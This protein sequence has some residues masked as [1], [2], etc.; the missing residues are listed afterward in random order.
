MAALV[1]GF[2]I[3][4]TTRNINVSFI[5]HNVRISHSKTKWTQKHSKDLN[6][7]FKLF[8]IH[9]S[10]KHEKIDYIPQKWHTCF[11][12]YPHRKPPKKC[13]HQSFH[14]VQWRVQALVSRSHLHFGEVPLSPHPHL[15]WYHKTH[16]SRS[17]DKAVNCNV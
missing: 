14:Y 11:L 6:L 13:Q 17:E 4:D 12:K 7:T 2:H 16:K 5:W 15:W 3:C 1:L 10:I 8:M 9:L